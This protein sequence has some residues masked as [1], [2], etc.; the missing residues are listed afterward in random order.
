[1]RKADVIAYFGGTQVAAARA[2]G[3]TKSA[4]SQWGDLIPLKCALKAQAISNGDL[5]LDMSVYQLPDIPRRVR[6]H[7]RHANA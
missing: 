1:M 4:V 5:P 2:L 7:R 3:V 6:S